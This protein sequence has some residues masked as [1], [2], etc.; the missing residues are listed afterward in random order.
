MNMSESEYVN[1]AR[2]YVKTYLQNQSFSGNISHPEDCSILIDCQLTHYEF[3]RVGKV[4]PLYQVC[5]DDNNTL[6]P[7]GPFPY[8]GQMGVPPV[9]D[10]LCFT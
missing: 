1:D 9:F 5:I 10:V 4:N 7:C 2:G 3:I 8:Q 6:L